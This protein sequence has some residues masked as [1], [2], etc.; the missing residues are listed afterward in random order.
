MILGWGL[1][2]I[3]GVQGLGREPDREKDKGLE[4]I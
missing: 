1:Q 4:V 2:Q 3:S